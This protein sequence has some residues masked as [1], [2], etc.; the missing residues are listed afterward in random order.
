MLTNVVIISFLALIVYNLFAGLIYMLK[1][2]GQT[3]RTLTSL[4]WRI[5]LSLLLFALLVVGRL[6]G[7]LEGNPDPVT[8]TPP[9]VYGD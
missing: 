9:A 5:G 7:F 1:D 2:R 4:K 8:G 3:E 6:T